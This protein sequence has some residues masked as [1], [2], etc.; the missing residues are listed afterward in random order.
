DQT[1][2]KRHQSLR[3][4]L[5]TPVPDGAGISAK[6]VLRLIEFTHPHEVNNRAKQKELDKMSHVVMTEL[7]EAPAKRGEIGRQHLRSDIIRSETSFGTSKDYTLQR[8]RR[9]RPDLAD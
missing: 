5:E 2:K 9:D 4:M 1:W 3:T 6:D 7:H 8:L